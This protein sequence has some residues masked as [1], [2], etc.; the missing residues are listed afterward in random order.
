MKRRRQQKRIQRG[1]QRLRHA[2]DP[3]TSPTAPTGPFTETWTIP[4]VRGE[5]PCGY[6]ISGYPEDRAAE[7]LVSLERHFIECRGVDM[8]GDVDGD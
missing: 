4:T 5:C 6:K 7:L 2:P 3:P 1:Q 8:T